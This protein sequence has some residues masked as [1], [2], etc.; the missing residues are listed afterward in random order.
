MTALIYCPFPNEEC[1]LEIGR[2]LIEEGLVACIN[3]GGGISSLFM[4][5]GR[6][7][8][9]SE[10]PAILKT[11][12]KLI[13]AAIARLEHLHPYESPAILGWHCDAAGSATQAWLGGLRPAD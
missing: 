2:K 1:A 3:V 13:D 11:N 10:V 6:I 8:E 5:Q 4:W 12:A 9:G 7:D